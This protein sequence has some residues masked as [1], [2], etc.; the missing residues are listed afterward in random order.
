MLQEGKEVKFSFDAFDVQRSTKI[1]KDHRD[2]V[3]SKFAELGYEVIKWNWDAGPDG[4]WNPDPDGVRFMKND[5]DIN[6]SIEV[7]GV[8]GKSL[9]PLIIRS[10][11]AT[12]SKS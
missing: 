2:Y 12:D 9:R 11:N 1:Y 8:V 3:R 5:S 4:K 10:E 7:I 6:L